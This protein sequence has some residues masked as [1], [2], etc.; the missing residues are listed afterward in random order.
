MV[1]SRVKIYVR[2]VLSAARAGVFCRGK[3]LTCM[4]GEVRA[5]SQDELN[6]SQSACVILSANVFAFK[7][8]RMMSSMLLELWLEAAVKLRFS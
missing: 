6:F 3:W 1:I 8:D 7:T 4:F 2:N 5:S